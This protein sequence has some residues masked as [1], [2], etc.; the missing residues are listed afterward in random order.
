M[1]GG[2]TIK[3]EQKENSIQK[4]IL[5]YL[6]GD[7]KKEIKGVGG[8]WL[9]VHGGSV[10]MPRGLPD[11]IGCYNGRFV[12]FEIKR[13]GEKP[14]RIQEYTLRL[15]EEAGAVT[16]VVYSVNDVQS[17]IELIDVLH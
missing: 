16:G 15:L 11:I 13:P 5:T 10:Y 7:P 14:R 9:N 6:K 1:N 4:E 3:T 8:W 2:R 12:A 17:V